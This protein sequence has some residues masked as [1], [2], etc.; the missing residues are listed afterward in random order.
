M[1]RRK[2][3]Q[4]CSNGLSNG[5]QPQQQQQLQQQKVYVSLYPQMMSAMEPNYET[6]SR[7]QQQVGV[8]VRECVTNM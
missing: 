5:I 3:Q 7:Q 1:K 4:H 6:L 8:T 2:Q